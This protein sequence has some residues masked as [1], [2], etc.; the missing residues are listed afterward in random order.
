MAPF[1]CMAVLFCD[2]SR[3]GLADRRRGRRRLR[4]VPAGGDGRLVLRP[5]Y[6][7]PGLYWIGYASW[8]D[9]TYLRMG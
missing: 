4:G 2:F 7:V 6:F 9:R 3:H 5:R 1:E 8:F